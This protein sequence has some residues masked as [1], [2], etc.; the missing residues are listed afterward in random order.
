M[1][2]LTAQYLEMTI[3]FLTHKLAVKEL[4]DMITSM[5][6]AFTRISDQDI[7][8]YFKVSNLVSLFLTHFFVRGV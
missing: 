3:E 1:G 7:G 4:H 5:I 2:P 6:D 8:E